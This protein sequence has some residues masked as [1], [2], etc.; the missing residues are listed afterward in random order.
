VAVGLLFDSVRYDAE[1]F[2]RL[3]TGAVGDFF[4]LTVIEPYV[5]R[6]LP[7]LV[8]SLINQ[9]ILLVGYIRTEQ[10]SELQAQTDRWNGLHSRA[11][12]SSADGL[13]TTDYFLQW[14]EQTSNAKKRD[15]LYCRAS[16]AAVK[17]EKFESALDIASRI[18]M[19]YRD[20]ATQFVL[21]HI[22]LKSAR[23]EHLEK[24]EQMARRDTDLA[25]RA[26]LFTL[27]AK[28][29]L[30]D[31]A[32]DITHARLLLEE[33]ERLAPKLSNDRERLSVLVG[34]AAVYSLFDTI[35]GS[36][37]FRAAV[38]IA[39]KTAG[40]TGDTYLARNLDIGGFYFDYSMY[41]QEFTFSEAIN[42]LG[43]A[44]FNETLFIIRELKDNLVRLKAII[45]ICNAALS[46][47]TY[48]GSVLNTK[49]NL[50]YGRV[51]DF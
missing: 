24:A 1:H 37:V 4:L 35:R 40:F 21:F 47:R 38:K 18:S 29:I 39:N 45:A 46:E 48:L 33:V 23:A 36:E 16:M 51:Q 19:E 11:N 30:D 31:K 6:Y 13:N 41:V 26:Y 12:K 50:S 14:A 25:R 17:E 49:R 7:A 2:E 32:Q 34:S 44:N 9:R 10:R 20:E 22:A 8:Q 15:Q 27:I 43:L 3:A 5:A 28:S 42:R